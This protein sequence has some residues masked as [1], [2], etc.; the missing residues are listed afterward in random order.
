MFWFFD[1]AY[2]DIYP[3]AFFDLLKKKKYFAFHFSM[4]DFE[5]SLFI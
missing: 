5:F 1:F 3:F 2:I 4:D